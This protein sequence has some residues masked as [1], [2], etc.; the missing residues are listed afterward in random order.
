[1]K[2]FITIIHNPSKQ[3]NDRKIFEISFKDSEGNYKGCLI[4]F[5]F[6]NDTPVIEVYRIDKGIDI[7]VS[8]KRE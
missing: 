3:K 5:E 6:I 8:E 4:S 7:R 1:M 2:K